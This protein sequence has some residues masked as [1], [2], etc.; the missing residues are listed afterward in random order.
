MAEDNNVLP[1][2]NREH[3]TRHDIDLFLVGVFSLFI[4]AKCVCTPSEVC[5]I[6]ADTSTLSV[7]KA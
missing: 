6:I 3:D 7:M 2:D 5:F 1:V 4:L